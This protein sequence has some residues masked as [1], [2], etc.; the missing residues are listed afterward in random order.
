MGMNINYSGFSKAVQLWQKDNGNTCS[1][2]HANNIQTQCHA[3]GWW[4]KVAPLHKI[5]LS[6]APSIKA[7]SAPAD[8]L[9][10]NEEQL[11][12]LWDRYQ[13]EMAG[14]YGFGAPSKWNNGARSFQAFLSELNLSPSSADTST[15]Q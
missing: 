7:F 5:R 14:N 3:C 13:N 8:S 1:V 10:M 2:C 15:R 12:D 6:L 11:L 9:G 4:G